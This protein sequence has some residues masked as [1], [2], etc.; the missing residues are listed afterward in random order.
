MWVEAVLKG[1]NG[2]TVGW[3]QRREA[4]GPSVVLREE[5][6]DG[7]AQPSPPWNRSLNN[8]GEEMMDEEAAGAE[9]RSAE[10]Q[11]DCTSC[12]VSPVTKGGDGLATGQLLPGQRATSE[13][14][15]T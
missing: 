14:Q 5:L 7:H 10:L 4:H 3:K 13:P 9:R 6:Q 8:R 11:G 12:W 15:W 2:A 1:G